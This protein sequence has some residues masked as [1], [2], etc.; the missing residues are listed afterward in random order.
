MIGKRVIRNS[1]NNTYNVYNVLDIA[2]NSNS[3][4]NTGKLSGNNNFIYYDS[5][6][7]NHNGCINQITID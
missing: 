3:N 2:K 4:K 1:N 5:G 6:A 7:N